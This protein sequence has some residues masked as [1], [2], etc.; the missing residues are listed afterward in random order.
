MS[1]TI[2]RHTRSLPSAQSP[3]CPSL[4]PLLRELL[5][6][7]SVSPISKISGSPLQAAKILSRLLR[8]TKAETLQSTPRAK[9]WKAWSLVRLEMSHPFS[10]HRAS[11]P[12]PSQY[13]KLWY[14]TC[15]LFQNTCQDKKQNCPQR[16]T[17]FFRWPV[18]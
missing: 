7:P 2:Y 15:I 10:S 9:E 18:L 1:V 5:V 3:R 14:K 12:G 4:L 6:S 11:V 17:N 8:K 16:A 13:L